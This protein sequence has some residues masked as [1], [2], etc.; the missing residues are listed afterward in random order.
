M[1]RIPSMV[2]VFL[3]FA[4]LR[5]QIPGCIDPAAINYNPSAGINDGSCVYA[6][7]SATPNLIATL[8]DSLKELSG[9]IKVCGTLLGHNDGGNLELLLS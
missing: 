3:C 5:A 1:A 8:S 9:L 7:S 6:V 4:V 2:L